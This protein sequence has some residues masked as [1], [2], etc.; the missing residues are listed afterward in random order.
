MGAYHQNC[1]IDPLRKNVVVQVASFWNLALGKVE[2][3]DS[4]I[5]GL[6]ALQSFMEQTLPEL[7]QQEM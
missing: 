3:R 7:L 1:L 6:V 5:N 4:G 2:Q